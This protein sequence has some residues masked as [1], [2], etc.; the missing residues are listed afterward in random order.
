M[1]NAALAT[2]FAQTLMGDYEDEAPWQAVRTLRKLGTRDVFDF[3]AEWCKSPTPLVRARGID[4]LA[5]L[6]KTVEH[7]SNSFPHEAYAIVS[8]LAET[9]TENRPLSSA[10]AALGHLDNEAAVPVIARFCSNPSQ[11]VRFNVACALGS[12]PNDDVSVK[13]LLFLT[14]D[15]DPDVRDWATFGLGVL[16]DQDSTD[17]REALF[18]ELADTNEDA[19]EEAMVGL[20]KRKDHR[21]LPYLFA[22]LNGP[23]V[24]VRVA[25]ATVLMLSMEADPDHWDAED[26]RVALKS[27]FPHS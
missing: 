13:T 9:E 17:I 12:Y 27:R 2:L 19:R 18:R 25:E 23:D 16:S 21:V 4:V 15:A 22:S 3:A 8:A 1:M 11:E 10:V 20:A 14:Q 5:Q 7:P 6:G 24:K 26:Y